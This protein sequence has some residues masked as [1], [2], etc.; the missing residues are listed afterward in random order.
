LIFEFVALAAAMAVLR[1][2]CSPKGVLV[3]VLQLPC[4]SMAAVSPSSFTSLQKVADL[5]RLVSPSELELAAKNSGF[6][7]ISMDAIGLP[8]GKQFSVQTFQAI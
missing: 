8:S 4:A 5:V 6:G 2:L 3:T 1:T 7:A